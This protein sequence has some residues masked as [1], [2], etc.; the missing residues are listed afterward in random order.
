MARICFHVEEAQWFYEDFIR[1]LDPTLPSMSLRSFCLRIFQHCP[2][3]SSFSVENHM[4]A[5]EEFLQYKTRIPVRGAILLNHDMDSTVLVKGWKKGANWSFPRGKINKD[6]DDL[7]CA[8][9]EVYEE[10]GFDIKAAGLVPKDEDAKYIQISMREQQIRLYIFRDI[11]MDTVFQPMTRKEISKIEW[12]NLSELP[13]FRKKGNNQHDGAAAASNANKFYMVAPFLVPLKKWVVQQKKKDRSASHTQ[14]IHMALD[15]PLTEDDIGNHTEPAQDPSVSTP[16]IETLEGATRE[17]QR[18]LKIQPP[19]MNAQPVVPEGMGVSLDKGASLMAI[20]QTKEQNPPPQQYVPQQMPVTGQNQQPH[21]PYDLVYTNAPQPH[22]PQHPHPTQ[23][24]PVQNYQPPPPFHMPQAYPGSMNMHQP[25]QN[26]SAAFYNQARFPPQPMVQNP[27]YPRYNQNAYIP[28]ANQPPQPRPPVLLHP[29]PLPPQ[30][31]QSLLTR[32]ILPTPNLP[33]VRPG[34]G[35]QSHVTL[36][37]QAGDATVQPPMMRQVAAQ[38]TAPKM[39]PPQPTGHKLSLLNAFKTD[40]PRKE[41]P[42][43]QIPVAQVPVSQGQPAL[44]QYQP[45]PWSNPPSNPPFAH[46][47]QEVPASA[48][49]PGYHPSAQDGQN[50]AA[51]LPKSSQPTDKH[52]SALLGM[53]KKQDPLSP[54]SSEATVRPNQPHM[55]SAALAGEQV[56]A[57]PIISS[58]DAVLAANQANGAPVRMNP[59]A[60]LPFH[61]LQ[62]LSRPKQTEN[63]VNPDTAAPKAPSA[64]FDSSANHESSPRYAAIHPGRPSPMNQSVSSRG[65]NEVKRSPHALLA[66][67]SVAS[68]NNAPQQ[69]NLGFPANQTSARRSDAN[70]EQKQKLLSLFGKSQASPTSFPAEEKGKGKEPAAYEQAPQPNAP[71]SR[72]ASLTGSGDAGSTTMS[73][74]NSQTPISPADRSFLLGFL[75]Q[76]SNS[77]S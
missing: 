54:T 28:R 6:E 18:L 1:P 33:D 38:Q 68:Y 57:K 13:A 69:P 16:A 2:L 35:P 63:R 30:V 14:R 58:A 36:P 15:E 34:P 19:A 7:D 29:Q 44:R 40:A 25:P 50:P 49:A 12:Y 27:N 77:G 60:N 66:Q 23:R 53:F 3:L 72:M 61:A 62:I 52:R 45:V 46:Q 21:T 75:Q 76:V 8:I 22:T 43:A 70:P 4:R 74:Q 26:M 31:Q 55:D 9:R 47:H 65:E 41:A 20:L 17:L 67:A 56:K 5:F 37:A 59:E 51:T 11:P 64:S 73:R 32:G 71:R 39:P 42:A 10:T 48:F 24:L